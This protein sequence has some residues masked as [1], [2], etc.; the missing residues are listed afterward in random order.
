[1]ANSRL[2]EE[3][4]RRPLVCDGAMGT[5]LMARG[6]RSGECGVLWNVDRGADVLA[7]HRAYREAGC[8]LITTNTFGGSPSA[9]ARHGLED[10]VAE[11]NAAAARLAQEAAGSGGFVL[12]DVGPFG[13][14]LEP[15]GDTSE[16]QA[17]D[18][19][20]RQIRALLEGGADAILVETMS[21]PAEVEV[22]VSA[23]KEAG[24]AAVI[25]TYAFQKSA[26]GSFRTMMGN[27]VA[28]ALGKARAAGAAVVGANCGTSLTLEDYVSLAGALVAA[29]GGA[30]VILQPNAGSPRMEG[31][32][33]VY[34]AT[35]EDMAALVP[36]LMAAG[37]RIIGGCCGTTPP[38][39][40]AMA[41]AVAR[42]RRRG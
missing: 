16:E 26:D 33:A 32:S 15:I 41:A 10:R 35:P 24:A 31:D 4:E 22:A 1:M 30:P 11:L 6:L 27:D 8:E 38:H 20:L 7:I 25:A 3:L 34:D 12:G 39:L 5:Q 37:V 19:F 21:D 40:K 28:D 36:R 23:A 2:L 14:F 13:D 17:R 42:Q 29:A 18:I 9:L